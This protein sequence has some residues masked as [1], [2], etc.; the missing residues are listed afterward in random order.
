MY[1]TARKKRTYD[2]RELACEAYVLCVTRIGTGGTTPQRLRRP[3]EE[4]TMT[5][6]TIQKILEN[7]DMLPQCIDNYIYKYIYI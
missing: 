5:R 3:K 1:K 7:H 2:I 6:S 4:F